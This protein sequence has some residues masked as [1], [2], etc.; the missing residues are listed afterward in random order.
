MFWFSV[1]VCSL[2][3]SR[4]SKQSRKGN[5]TSVL[6]K[7]PHWVGEGLS[8]GF[9]KKKGQFGGK[10]RNGA[11]NKVAVKWESTVNGQIGRFAV[12]ADSKQNLQLVRIFVWNILAT[13]S[14]VLVFSKTIQR[15]FYFQRNFPETLNR[16]LF[17]RTAYSVS[18]QGSAFYRFMWRSSWGVHTRE[19]MDNGRVKPT[20]VINTFS[21]I[22]YTCS[23]A[24]EKLRGLIFTNLSTRTRPI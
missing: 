21:K 13:F 10:N 12:C 4:V 24:L 14:Y 3:L 6:T 20:T 8:Q 23:I 22:N 1:V 11:N 9:L 2:L 15:T 19:Q 17:P 5:L 16:V 18:C 7:W